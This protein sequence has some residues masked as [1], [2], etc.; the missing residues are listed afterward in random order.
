M[1]NK[2]RNSVLRPPP[3]ETNAD[4]APQQTDY[5]SIERPP[6][7]IPPLAARPRDPELRE[8]L[9][10]EP[11]RRI[12]QRITADLPRL[13]DSALRDFLVRAALKD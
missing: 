10:G 7:D 12:E 2:H 1:M 8:R 13:I 4:S 5:V 6:P 11:A 3:L 9:A